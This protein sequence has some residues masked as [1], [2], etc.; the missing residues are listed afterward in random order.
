M[1]HH[2]EGVVAGRTE[3]SLIIE[4]GGIG[5]QVHTSRKTL[6]ETVGLTDSVKLYTSLIVRENEVSLFGFST[7]GERQLFELLL[8]VSGIGPKV[9][10]GILSSITPE[11]FQEAILTESRASLS[12]VKGI[13]KKTSERLII[14]LKDKIAKIPLERSGAPVK[15]RHAEMALRALTQNLGFGER[16]ARKA[17]EAINQEHGDLSAEQL[18]KQALGYLSRRP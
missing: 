6:E 15:T 8:T 5:Y 13:G 11:R 10:I 14:E 4:M 2:I 16:E 1:I 18:I 9:A 12:S 17:L 7:A 3:S